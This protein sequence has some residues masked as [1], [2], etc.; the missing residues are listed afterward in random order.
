MQ[1]LI[2]AVPPPSVSPRLANHP[3]PNNKLMRAI[4]LRLANR[5]LPGV[6]GQVTT[7]IAAIADGRHTLFE[8]NIIPDTL[9]RAPYF[10]AVLWIPNFGP[11]AVFGASPTSQTPP[12]RIGTGPLADGQTGQRHASLPCSMSWPLLGGESCVL[13]EGLR[14]AY[15]VI[16]LKFR[17]PRG[18]DAGRFPL[19]RKS[20]V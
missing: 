12:C 9:V 1:G 6:N 4:S 15:Y 13:Q 2:G 10:G 14:G 16:V 5:D 7:S 3:S 18:A 11:P 17:R 19:D 8:N 20:V